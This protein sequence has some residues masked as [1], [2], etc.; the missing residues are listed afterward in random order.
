M[1]SSTIILVDQTT[2]AAIDQSETAEHINN[3]FVSIGPKFAENFNLPWDY[4]GLTTGLEIP[5][6]IIQTVDVIEAAKNIDAKKSSAVPHLSS[7]VIKDAM[8]IIPDK[9]AFMFN[10]SLTEKEFPT[11][12]KD[13]IVT[14]LPKP[15][16]KS[17]VTNYR[18]ISQIPLPGK[19]L[20]RIV[21][22]HISNYLETNNLLNPKQGG[23]RKNHSTIT[24]VANFTNDLFHNINNNEH[25]IATFI[26]MSKAFDVVNHNILLLKCG[27]LG[28]NGNIQNWLKSYLS[29]RTQCTVANGKTSSKARLKCGVPQGSILG[30]LMFLIYVNDIDGLCDQTELSSYADD[31]V[32]YASHQ[33][34]VTAY[35]NVQNDL[36]HLSH[37]CQINKLTINAKKSHSMK[38]GSQALL[39]NMV[40]PKL[41]LNDSE[42]EY[43]EDFNYLGIQLDQHLKFDK[44]INQMRAKTA[45][46]LYMFG[47]LRRFMT[48]RQAL[49]IYKSK[50]LPY[51]EYGG[52]LVHDTNQTLLT[53]LQRLQNRGLK[54]A[55]YSPPRTR[56]SKI[57]KDGKINFLEERRSKQI[58][59]HAFKM[60]KVD[61]N[62]AIPGRE[63]RL[64]DAP[65]LKT[66]HRRLQTFKRSVT[67]KCS[68]L[69][70]DLGVNDRAIPTEEEFFNK[71]Y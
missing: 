33:D 50:L 9:F 37:W 24:T 7:K 45:H 53:K 71:P 67:Y 56:I 68:H 66:Y 30:P 49:A 64:H 12:W 55:L 47:Y 16:D 62:L 60:T 63:T 18:P 20:E 13:A 22:T 61:T 54:I 36:G 14:P 34:P 70:N 6:L 58:A 39:H 28:L 23:F 48:A 69:W 2:G 3:Y 8:L 31:T 38:F 41:K 11:D 65:V 17:N 26:D 1:P 59:V 35:I 29:N 25:S 52:I 40:V 15:G 44:Q 10:L 32:I 21:H 4:T 42:L 19:V 27:K 46:K 43:V 57:H 51:L 5:E